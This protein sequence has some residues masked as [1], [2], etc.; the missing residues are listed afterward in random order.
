MS[1]DDIEKEI[2]GAWGTDEEFYKE[3]ER[4]CKQHEES[5][6]DYIEYDN[7]TGLPIRAVYLFKPFQ[8]W[9]EGNALRRAIAKA[10]KEAGDDIGKSLDSFMAELEYRRVPHSLR[11]KLRY[12][13]ET[14]DHQAFEA[15]RKAEAESRAKERI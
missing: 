5:G 1:S 3:L 2:R 7:K 8:V 9:A 6:A 11:S 14:I 4:F 10:R 12:I 13:V 15:G